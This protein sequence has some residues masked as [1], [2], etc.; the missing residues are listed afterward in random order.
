MAGVP[1]PAAR[2]TTPPY[3]VAA[4]DRI[5]REL[6]LSPTTAAILVRRGHETVEGARSFLE[7]DE[8]HDPGRFGGMDAACQVVLEHVRRGSPI[9][10]HGDYDVDGVA[11]T[12]ILAGALRALGAD[13]SWHLPGRLEDGYGLSPATV[14]A[15]ARRGTG[16]LLTA[17]CAITAAAE[18]DL[19]KRHG[20]DVVVTDHHRPAD[21]LPD[22]PIVHP[23]VGGYPFEGLCAA[24]VAHKLSAA[25][26]AAAGM[27]PGRADEELDLVALATVC[28]VVPLVGE[29]R[30]LV[31]EG[32]R[33]L[34]RTRRPGLR[35]LMRSAAVDPGAIDERAVG[36]RLGPRLNAAGRLRRADAALELL[37]TEDEGRATEVAEELELLNHERR[38]TE[39][40]ILF[41]AEAAR[42]EQ[43]DAPA[44]VLAGEGWH[45]GV[46]GIV[47]SRMAQRH[48]RPCVMIALEREGG[49]GSGRSIPAFDLHA[50]LTACASHL[51][52]FGGHRAAAGLE[53]DH[54][55]IDRFRSAFATH[56]AAV[57]SA[58]DLRPVQKI[59]AVVPGTD[60]GLP[61]A[62]ELR[63]LAP[64]GEGNPE[65]TLLVPAARVAQVAPMGD[66]G[67][68]ARF[69]LV[70]GG[71]HARGV[72]FRTPPRSLASAEPQ[73]AA[74]QVEIREWMGA[75]EPRL[76][77][78]A[79][80]PTE[81]GEC[82]VVGEPADFFEALELELAEYHG[83]PEREPEARRAVRD[84][85]GAGLA[86]LAGELL[87]SREDVLIVVADVARRRS[88]LERLVAGLES[89]G[90]RLGIASWA[91][92]ARDPSV[93]G[94]FPHLLALDPHPGGDGVEVLARAPAA[95]E[96]GFAHLGWGR[97]EADFALAVARAE[98]DLREPLTDLYRS[99]RGAGSAS[100]PELQQLLWGRG[101]YA[102]SPALC[103]RMLR[104]LT[105]LG[106]VAQERAEGGALSCRVLEAER[107][108]LEAS[109]TYRT[110][111][112]RLG[113]ARRYLMSEGASESTPT[114]DV[115]R[116]A[117]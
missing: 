41:A 70:S 99:L 46:I 105:E 34:A 102:R 76:L 81:P 100:G 15:L 90:E 39:T 37:L 44:Y 29:N 21:R 96:S 82:R 12:A 101:R 63:G 36:F 98:L 67:Q 9:V 87:S 65:P 42:A 103:A 97:P 26:M 110:A 104:V 22:C 13:P 28:D 25:L 59:D 6:G 111:L 47:A 40:R 24:G 64:F 95:F 32:L 106:L 14:D 77:L 2:W 3:S 62:E 5:G 31:R 94:P 117:A 4:A 107:T 115:S 10:I 71:A 7:A 84:R 66:E 79:L 83:R 27:D 91:T 86:G 80:C 57:L 78:R 60:L 61:L 8:R 56:A 88:T 55:E 109:A 23:S 38:D 93:A 52:R 74:V 108:A 49:R 68:H 43:A 18:V 75:V 45:P 54:D 35:A 48:H 116:D 69:T 85:R 112:R 11:S 33:A 30:R 58:H 92:L 113:E 17:D 72:A 114:S 16:L 20:I 53:I 51:R 50:A 19:A 73:D 89:G 1:A